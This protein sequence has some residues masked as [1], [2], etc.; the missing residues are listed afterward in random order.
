M[1]LREHVVSGGHDIRAAI[2]ETYNAAADK[3]RQCDSKTWRCTFRGKDVVL[4]DAA[5]KVILWVDRF[6]SVGDVVANA[7]PIYAGLPWAGIRVI[8]EVGRRKPNYR[9]SKCR[10]LIVCRLRCLS[11]AK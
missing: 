4:S 11:N 9:V 2:D 7:A 8:L 3:K 10:G 5:K 6:K 1:T